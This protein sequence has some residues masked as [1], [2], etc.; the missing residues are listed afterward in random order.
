MKHSAEREAFDGLFNHVLSV[1]HEE[2]K[3]RE[4]A[5]RKQADANPRK[6]GPKRKDKPSASDHEGDAL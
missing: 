3:R 5:Y 1:S 6:R 2:V 4:E